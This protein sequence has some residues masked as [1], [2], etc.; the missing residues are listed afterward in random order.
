[1]APATRPCLV[2]HRI[3]VVDAV[4]NPDPPFEETKITPFARI[5][6]G[7]SDRKH[8]EDSITIDPELAA[9][10]RAMTDARFPPA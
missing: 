6:V 7:W 9:T 4:K 2:I 3:A 8:P 5:T 1:M 10:L